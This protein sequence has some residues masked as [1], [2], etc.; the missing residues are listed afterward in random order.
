M[1]GMEP[2]LAR[3]RR[4]PLAPAPRAIGGGQMIR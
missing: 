2:M 3:S 4:N 1:A